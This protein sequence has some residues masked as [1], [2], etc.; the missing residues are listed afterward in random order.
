MALD[1]PSENALRLSEQ[2][3]LRVCREWLVGLRARSRSQL[4]VQLRAPRLGEKRERER[5]REELLDRPCGDIDRRLLVPLLREMDLVSG[6]RR[7]SRVF[8]A[9]QVCAKDLDV[10]LCLRLGVEHD[11]L[12]I[13]RGIHLD[14]APLRSVRIRAENAFT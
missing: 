14:D 1:T 3:A 6:Q 10:A 13:S 4:F 8:F 11:G 12:A 7:L 9:N 2:I 5:G